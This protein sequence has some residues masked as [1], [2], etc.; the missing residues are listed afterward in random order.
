MRR[1]DFV[2]GA[3]SLPLPTPDV[4]LHISVVQAS[5]GRQTRLTG[6]NLPPS[7]GDWPP[8]KGQ[9][10]AEKPG[11]SIVGR[12]VHHRG[13]S[14]MLRRRGADGHPAST[15]IAEVVCL[16]FFSAG[17]PCWCL[18]AS[19]GALLSLLCQQ[20][21]PAVVRVVGRGAGLERL[22]P[23]GAPYWY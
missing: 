21:S 13:G 4:H 23:A 14:I 1:L 2:I 16:A 20:G 5:S 8:L 6:Q 19:R 22:L 3:L 17:E 9:V 18:C 12:G 7:R 10:A 15:R 11:L